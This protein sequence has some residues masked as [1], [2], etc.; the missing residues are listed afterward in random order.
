M[1]QQNLLLLLVFAICMTPMTGCF[2]YHESAFKGT[3]LDVDTKQP[4][5]GAVVVAE[6]KK[7]SM[8]VGAG[9]I[10]SIIKVRETLTDKEGNFNISSYLTIKFPFTWKTQSILII[11]K[12]GYAN[13]ELGSW[14]FIGKVMPEEQESPWFLSKELKY[15]LRGAGIVELPKVAKREDRKHAWM[16]TDIF[17]AEIKSSDLPILF[18][19]IGEEGC[20]MGF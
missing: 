12:P 4:V 20:E 19:M 15:K 9:S 5:E 7:E 1:R 18:K 3:I 11:Y 8:G 14:H 6:Y 16:D 17:G 2:V 10:S 13:L